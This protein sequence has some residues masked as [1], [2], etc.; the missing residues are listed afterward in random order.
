M[1]AR[2]EV[3]GLYW[4]LRKEHERCERHGGRTA[5]ADRRLVEI[6]VTRCSEVEEWIRAIRWV[7]GLNPSRSTMRAVG[8]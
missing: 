5:V 8:G 1:R 2:E 3:W 7:L 6:G 4:L